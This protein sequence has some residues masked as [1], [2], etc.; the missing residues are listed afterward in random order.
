VNYRAY[1]RSRSDATDPLG[2]G[3]Y[4]G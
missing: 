3:P 4:E 1:I 2:T